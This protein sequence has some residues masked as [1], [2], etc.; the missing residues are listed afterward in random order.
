MESRTQSGSSRNR[1]IAWLASWLVV[2]GAIGFVAW[3][4]LRATPESAPIDLPPI[5]TTR[6]GPA[7]RAP[8]PASA[9]APEAVRIADDATP[10]AAI[11]ASSLRLTVRAGDDGPIVPGIELIALI[12]GERHGVVTRATADSKGVATLTALPEGVVVVE[13]RRA[14]PFAATAHAFRLD[15]QS[16]HAADFIVVHGGVVIGRAVTDE[17]PNAAPIQGA[18][19]EAEIG[20]RFDAR[21]TVVATSDADGRFR[22]EALLDRASDFEAAPDGTVRPTR[23]LAGTFVVRAGDAWRPVTENVEADAVVDLGDL[24]FPAEHRIAGH[25]VDQRDLPLAGILVS[26]LPGRPLAARLPWETGG[27]ALAGEAVTDA[28]GAF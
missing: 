20:D 9:P 28:S 2:A 6:G 26:T 7:D 23:F 15:A 27:G 16:P 4:L 3:T 1:L 25:V 5:V 13:S 17:G 18:T 12:E 22:I 14:P 10:P 21:R 24:A 19:I 11:G 8:P